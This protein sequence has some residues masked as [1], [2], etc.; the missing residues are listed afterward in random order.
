SPQERRF[1]SHYARPQLPIEVQM[2]LDQ[3]SLLQANRLLPRLGTSRRSSRPRSSRSGASRRRVT[4]P[5]TRPRSRLSLREE[6]RLFPYAIPTEIDGKHRQS[7][8]SVGVYYG[9]WSQGYLRILQGLTMPHPEGVL[10]P[11]R[12]S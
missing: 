7:T 8:Q 11:L 5:L 9:D 2:S 10:Q 3:T 1:V 4:L 6:R 12:T